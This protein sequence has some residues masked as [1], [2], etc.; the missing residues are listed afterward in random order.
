YAAA[1]A[2]LGARAVTP[3]QLPRLV[4]AHAR[5]PHTAPFDIPT[6]GTDRTAAGLLDLLP[7]VA[8]QEL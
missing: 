2:S 3:A 4:R 7:T 1:Y 5:N 8:G 6:E